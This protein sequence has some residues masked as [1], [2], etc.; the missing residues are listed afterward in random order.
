MA[1]FLTSTSN[2]N[3]YLNNLPHYIYHRRLDNTHGQLHHRSVA[4]V[5]EYDLITQVDRQVGR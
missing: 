2:L 3:S 5:T 4:V 1:S